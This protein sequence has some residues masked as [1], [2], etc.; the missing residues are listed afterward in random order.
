MY[1]IYDYNAKERISFLKKI[2]YT[3][4]KTGMKNRLSVTSTL[5]CGNTTLLINWKKGM[6]IVKIVDQDIADTYKKQFDILW[7]YKNK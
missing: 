6:K 7:N 5:I 1:H 4:A 2:K 3:Y